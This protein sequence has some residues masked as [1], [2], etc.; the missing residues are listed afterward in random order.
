MKQKIRLYP[1]TSA[2]TH[3]LAFAIQPLTREER[4][5]LTAMTF[6]DLGVKHFTTGAFIV[7]VRGLRCLNATHHG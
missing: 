2:F 6:V 5:A 7:K 1:L 3:V 4:S